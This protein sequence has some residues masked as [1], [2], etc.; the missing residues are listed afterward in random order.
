MAN[1]GNTAAPQSYTFP[2]KTQHHALKEAVGEI[3]VHSVKAV[4][5][6]RKCQDDVWANI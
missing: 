3:N 6:E 4:A 5:M 1:D 2:A